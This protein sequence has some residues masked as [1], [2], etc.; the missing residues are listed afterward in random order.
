MSLAR[1]YYRWWKMTLMFQIW[2]AKWILEEMCQQL[3][4]TI[5][6][7]LWIARSAHRDPR[8]SALWSTCTSTLMTSAGHPGSFRRKVL[9]TSMFTW[10][11]H[12]LRLA[13]WSH[14]QPLALLPNKRISS[15][16]V[17]V[18]INSCTLLQI[19]SLFYKTITSSRFI[20]NLFLDQVVS[21]LFL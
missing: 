21:K 9:P 19:T 17:T 10:I 2:F 7:T 15:N 14:F 1:K 3:S 8:D 16:C 18:S 6:G 12:K 20:L 13:V 5:G 11:S 4:T